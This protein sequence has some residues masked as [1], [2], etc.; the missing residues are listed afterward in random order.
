MNLSTATREI[1]IRPPTR[2]DLSTFR[3]LFPFWVRQET[4]RVVH[5]RTVSSMT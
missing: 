4:P 2:S 3:V 1:S 5:A